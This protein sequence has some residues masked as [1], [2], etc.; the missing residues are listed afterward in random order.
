[1]AERDRKFVTVLPPLPNLTAGEEERAS[2]WGGGGGFVRRGINFTSDVAHQLLT[3]QQ[4][5]ALSFFRRENLMAPPPL[6]C[7]V[8]R[9][10][11]ERKR[12]R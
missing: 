5:T 10:E 3:W 11:R 1:M 6:F 7:K 8:G 12:E 9:D 2:K 4:K